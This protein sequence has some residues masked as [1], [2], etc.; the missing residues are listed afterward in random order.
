LT[1]STPDRE[2]PSFAEVVRDH[3][4][5]VFRFL[6][7]LAGDDHDAEELTQETF[8]RA[9]QGWAKVRPDTH[10]RPW[11]LKIARNAYLDLYRRR[12][13]VRFQGLPGER[14]ASGTEVGRGIE[15]SEEAAAVRA[16]VDELPEMARM[17]FLL[18][19]EGEL[20]FAEIA[21]ELGMSE[22]AARWHMHQARTRLLARM[23]P[24]E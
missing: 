7:H 16:A 18:R 24:K 15:V 10:P 11:L 12:Q 22:E 5:P 1:P 14:V 19:V 8:L 3:W 13:T 2:P 23:S 4:V 20:S 9:W 17:V 21:A 6:R